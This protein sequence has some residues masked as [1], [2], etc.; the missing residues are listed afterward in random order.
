MIK[1]TFCLVRAPHLTLPEF[2]DYWLN[3]HAP[4]VTSFREVLRIRKYV[5]AHS[6][7]PSVSEV[8]RNSR[9]LPDQ[10]DGVAQLWWDNMDDVEFQVTDRDARRAGR[11]L[12]EDERNFIDLARSPAWWGRE[13]EIF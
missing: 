5:Q 13:H 3:K 4:L 2:Q 1:L 8:M 7:D 10:F 12:V 11:T 9:G 6:L